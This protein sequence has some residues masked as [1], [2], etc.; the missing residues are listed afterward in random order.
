MDD[1][2]LIAFLDLLEGDIAAHPERL[3][4][5]P[6]PLVDRA[7]ELVRGVEIDLDARL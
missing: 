5:V 2:A 4:P 1:P 3:Q 6:D 7:R